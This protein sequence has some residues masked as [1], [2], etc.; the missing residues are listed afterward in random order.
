MEVIARKACWAVIASGAL[1]NKAQPSET[2]H[3]CLYQSKGLR[4]RRF[5]Q[6]YS[7]SCNLAHE[8]SSP[9]FRLTFKISIL[10]LD[11]VTGK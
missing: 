5:S 4:D 7:N 1:S 8:T 3:D 6:I 11:T 9:G 2:V 10:T